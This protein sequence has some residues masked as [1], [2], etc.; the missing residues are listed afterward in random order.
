MRSRA[1]QLY[2]SRA[3]APQRFMGSSLSPYG[4]AAGGS[5]LQNVPLVLKVAALVPLGC[6]RNN[7]KQSKA[8][9]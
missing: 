8:A 4:F 1:V 5:A 3:S 6:S 7:L 9:T 2:P